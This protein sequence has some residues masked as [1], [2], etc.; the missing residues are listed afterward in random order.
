MN[1]LV[2]DL[3]FPNGGRRGI[4]GEDSPGLAQQYPGPRLWGLKRY[5]VSMQ[6]FQSRSERYLHT[7]WNDK[8]AQEDGQ[9]QDINPLA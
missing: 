9:E 1:S 4:P 5:D 6:Y 8:E 2:L 3:L 7:S